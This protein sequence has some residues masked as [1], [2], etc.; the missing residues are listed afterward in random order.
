MRSCT[1]EGRE[2]PGLR[3]REIEHIGDTI[4]A[5]EPVVRE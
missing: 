3:R 2:V 5:S 1:K 4:E